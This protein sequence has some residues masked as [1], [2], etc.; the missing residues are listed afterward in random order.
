LEHEY[1]WQ[2]PGNGTHTEYSMK[3]AEE[4]DDGPEPGIAHSNS[5]VDLSCHR[6]REASSSIQ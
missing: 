4:V 1:S 6:N 5:Y 2:L 3:K